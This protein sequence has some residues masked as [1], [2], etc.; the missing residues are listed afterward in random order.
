M[1]GQNI[2]TAAVIDPVTKHIRF[3][4]RTLPDGGNAAEYAESLCG[5]QHFSIIVKYPHGIAMTDTASL[6]ING[7]D[8]HL[9]WAGLL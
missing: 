5:N 4:P 8:P 3:K 7:V 2:D 1:R 6:S 9:L